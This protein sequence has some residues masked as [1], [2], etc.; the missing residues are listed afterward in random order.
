MESGDVPRAEVEERLPWNGCA[1]EAA[2]SNNA[3][4]LSGSVMVHLRN[5]KW[6]YNE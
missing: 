4:D 5:L 6:T 3:M 2:K 1:R